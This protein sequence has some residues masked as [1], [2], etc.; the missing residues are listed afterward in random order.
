[1]TR[2]GPG[3]RKELLSVGTLALA[4][5]ATTVPVLILTAFGFDL[6]LVPVGL[7]EELNMRV[8]EFLVLWTVACSVIGWLRVLQ[9]RGTPF[10]VRIWPAILVPMVCSSIPALGTIRILGPL[11][12][13]PYEFIIPALAVLLGVLASAGLYWQYHLW[14]RIGLVGVCRVCEYDLTGNE[15]GVCPECG[16][17]VDA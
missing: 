7:R 9:L 16:T 2:D 17:K 13:R 14:R 5:V 8:H 3:D 12:W 4:L 10:S 1:M 11:P 15:C 6:L